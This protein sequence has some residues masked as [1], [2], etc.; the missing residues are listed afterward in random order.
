MQHN[1]A[2]CSR[3]ISA[4]N[5]VVL[6]MGNKS[7]VCTLCSQDFTRKYSGY[8]HNRDLHHNEAK[9]VR[10]MDYLVGRLAGEYHQGDPFTYRSRDKQRNL[11]ISL[12]NTRAH[13][14]LTTSIAHD[15]SVGSLAGGPL[16]P[17]EN[18]RNQKT[19]ISSVDIHSDSLDTGHPSKFDEIKKL[20]GALYPAQNSATLLEKLSMRIIEEEGNE[21]FLDSCLHMLRKQM[22]MMEASHYLFGA[23]TK[24]P[25]RDPLYNHH[26]EHLPEPTRDKLA[27]IEEILKG[28]KHEAYVWEDIEQLIKKCEFTPDHTFLDKEL[29]YC[30]RNRSG[31]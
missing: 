6:L 18:V 7:W 28:I 8:R 9:I 4:I 13:K 27:Q 22:N 1:V 11:T 23:S 5:S 26:V 31:R 2:L 20:L 14:P 15:N 30:K 21:S 3:F 16:W 19:S 12:S 29:E 25:P 10:M 17:E 24:N